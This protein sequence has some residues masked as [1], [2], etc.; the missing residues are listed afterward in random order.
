M[1]FGML[2]TFNDLGIGKKIVHSVFKYKY[3]I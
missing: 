3:G 2:C 1:V